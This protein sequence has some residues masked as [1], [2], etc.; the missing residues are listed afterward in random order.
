MC[1]S[2][3]QPPLY[4]SVALHSEGEKIFIFEV[5][6]PASLSSSGSGGL[7]NS[8]GDTVRL[9]TERGFTHLYYCGQRQGSGGTGGIGSIFY[10]NN[11]PETVCGP[12]GGVQ[13]SLCEALQESLTNRVP[14]EGSEGGLGEHLVNAIW[15]DVQLPAGGGTATPT[16]TTGLGVGSSGSVLT[17]DADTS[18]A[19]Q[20]LWRLL[21]VLLLQV[22]EQ[23][24]PEAS[25]W[26]RRLG[27]QGGLGPSGEA[28]AKTLPDGW[29]GGAIRSLWD[30]LLLG[31]NQLAKVVERESPATSL[32]CGRATVS[33]S[34]C[35][36]AVSASSSPEQVYTHT[37]THTH[38]N[39]Q[40]HTQ[41]YNNVCV[42]VCFCVCVYYI[43]VCMYYIYYIYGIEY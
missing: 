19:Q 26:T 36:E 9:G 32:D 1:A 12:S 22:S 2:A 14:P 33:G 35:I 38:T 42:S 18:A 29:M 6:P 39:T 43:Y 23:A 7:V 5:P 11:G 37:H 10:R 13:C 30:T 3:L 24:H 8:A 20:A 4:A 16:R 28:R 41:T 15:G 17:C 34:R 21:R 40:T 27:G 31:I 25:S